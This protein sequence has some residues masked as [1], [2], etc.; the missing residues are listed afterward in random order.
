MD[1]ETNTNEAE[2]VISGYYR[3]VFE[4]AKRHDSYVCLEE[5]IN[6]KTTKKGTR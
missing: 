4:R 1:K 6:K 3:I 5:E 2:R